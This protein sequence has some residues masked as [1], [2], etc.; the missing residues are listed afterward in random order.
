MECILI[1]DRVIH[2]CFEEYIRISVSVLI[3][4]YVEEFARKMQTQWMVR[5]MFHVPQCSQFFRDIPM[6]LEETRAYIESQYTYL[7]IS[8]REIRR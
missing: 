5:G 2:A 8:V 7:G 4:I 3:V 6:W 1:M